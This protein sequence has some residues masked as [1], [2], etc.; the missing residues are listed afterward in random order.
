MKTHDTDVKNAIVAH[1]RAHARAKLTAAAEPEPAAAAEPAAAHPSPPP[2]HPGP[3]PPHPIAP[4]PHPSPPP[5]SRPRC[6]RRRHPSSKRPQ[7]REIR[8]PG[9]M[10]RGQTAATPT[11]HA[12][13]QPVPLV[14]PG[15]HD[16]R[17]QVSEGD[18]DA[19]CDLVG[20]CDYSYD[21][22]RSTRAATNIPG[23][24]TRV[25]LATRTPAT[26]CSSGFGTS[27]P[28]AETAAPRSAILA[29]RPQVSVF[30]QSGPSDG[31]ASDGAGP[32]RRRRAFRRGG[33]SD[34]DGPSARVRCPPDRRGP[35]DEAGLPATRR[36]R[37]RSR[38]SRRPRRSGKSAPPPI[39]CCFKTAEI[40]RASSP[41]RQ[42][43]IFIVARTSPSDARR[44][45]PAPPTRASPPIDPSFNAQGAA[46]SV[47]LSPRA[48]GRSPSAR[49]RRPSQAS[50]PTSPS[51]GST[52]T[53]RAPRL[54]WRLPSASA[55]PSPRP[56][57]LV[58]RRPDASVRWLE[59]GSFQRRSPP[60]PAPLGDS[61]PPSTRLCLQR[62]AV[63]SF[64]YDS[65]PTPRRHPHASSS[66]A[67]PPRPPARA[68]AAKAAAAHATPEVPHLARR[69]APRES[70]YGAG[71]A[72]GASGGGAPEAGS[73]LGAARGGRRCPYRR[74]S[75]R[76]ARRASCS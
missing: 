33:P 61:H 67:P 53:A 10:R 71:G 16:P 45:P 68:H 38:P 43:Y 4:P 11:T 59:N 30:T 40:G 54:A 65:P 24:F 64:P 69:V 50:A 14:P 37:P 19:K 22:S 57:S 31:A 46:S 66:P 63:S 35:P 23:E 70:T 62:D 3:P 52:R 13:D 29:G 2:P 42:L 17:H 44:R 25:N 51:A 72:S 39:P 60:S 48:G 41:R 21:A 76:S 12:R 18:C 28:R 1:A 49:P 47:T 75:I 27:R 15:V 7:R 74:A 58:R 56:S 32:A 73:A 8:L 6:R 26:A 20:T 34:R 55:R 9:A 5:P 36:P